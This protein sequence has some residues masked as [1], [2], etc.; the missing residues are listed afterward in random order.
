MINFNPAI[1]DPET[2]GC[3]GWFAKLSEHKAAIKD[4]EAACK[5]GTMPS[6]AQII[7]L[8]D[9]VCAFE[10]DAERRGELHAQFM[11]EARASDI[12]EALNKIAAIK[13]G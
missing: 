6:T 4:F 5:T 2:P 10:P 7:A 12:A 8:I 3:F 13:A 11:A 9:A 1:P